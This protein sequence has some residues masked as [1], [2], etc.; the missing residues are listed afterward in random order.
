MP[1]FPPSEES[2]E[3]DEE[4]E[5]EKE[6]AKK[7]DEIYEISELKIDDKECGTSGKDKN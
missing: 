4:E 5:E 3:S 6:E 2:S 7:K 1:D